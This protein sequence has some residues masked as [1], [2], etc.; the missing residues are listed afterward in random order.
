MHPYQY[1][2][3]PMNNNGHMMYPQQQYQFQQQQPQQY[4]Q[5][6]YQQFQQTQFYQQ[7]PNQAAYK[8][9]DYSLPPSIYNQPTN[10]MQVPMAPYSQSKQ[11]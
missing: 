1:N 11:K 6:Q 3:Q 2:Q 10:Q 8:G 9:I 7:Q 5:Q 4:Q